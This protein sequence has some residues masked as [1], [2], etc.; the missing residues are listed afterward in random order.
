MLFFVLLACGIT[1]E[2]M[3]E[4]GIEGDTLEA[5]EPESVESQ[6]DPCGW[7][8]NQNEDPLSLTGDQACGSQVYTQ[9]CSVCHMED[10]SGGNSGK[11]LMGRMDEFDDAQLVGIIKSGQGTMPPI[12]ISSQEITDVIAFLRDSF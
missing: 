8:E 6:E 5:S 10:G 4:T 2:K 3:E 11:R 7:Q 12:A 1:T 9:S